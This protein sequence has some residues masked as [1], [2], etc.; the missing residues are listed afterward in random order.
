MTPFAQSVRVAWRAGYTDP[1]RGNAVQVAPNR[2]DRLAAPLN[3]A[4]LAFP[5]PAA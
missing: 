4:W 1:S 2:I 3:P 5:S